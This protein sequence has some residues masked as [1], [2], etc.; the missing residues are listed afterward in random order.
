[1]R[2]LKAYKNNESFSVKGYWSL[3]F[4]KQMK[5]VAGILSYS[6]EK[7][8]LEL[9][10]SFDEFGEEKVS[11]NKVRI[12]GISINNTYITLFDCHRKYQKNSNIV[13][14]KYHV[15][16]FCIGDLFIESLEKSIFYNF[17]LQTSNMKNWFSFQLLDVDDDETIFNMTFDKNK[18]G[19]NL[20]AFNLESERLVIKETYTSVVRRNIGEEIKID[21]DNYLNVSSNDVLSIQDCNTIARKIISVF[22]LLQGQ[23]ENISF[24]E[25]YLIDES[26]KR[27]PIEK[28]RYYFTPLRKSQLT[29]VKNSNFRFF[30]NDIRGN[31]ESILSLYFE[32]NELLNEIIQMYIGDIE[33]N[34][35]I[36]TKFLN[37]ARAL[38]IYSRNFLKSVESSDDASIE[39]AREQLIKILE[40]EY[41]KNNKIYSYFYNKINYK[42]ET[43][44][45]SRISD[46]LRLLPENIKGNLIKRKNKSMNKSIKSFVSY[47]VQTRNYHTHGDVNQEKY[48]CL[49]TDNY[50]LFLM[51]KKMTLIIEY[52][53]L[54]E[55]GMDKES[56]SNRL[57]N[58]SQYGYLFP[59]ATDNYEFVDPGNA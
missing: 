47:I 20:K 42:S 48:S 37:N 21:I 58:S 59:P 19:N 32:K 52:L 11:N 49:I 35:F 1:M 33:K 13:F 40:D 29:P 7:I 43:N 34:P 25:M 45:N 57:L 28:V 6:E 56:V 51:N 14:V 8:E 54:T 38:E 30:Y 24:L 22:T 23:Y 3:S 55:L 12:E 26:N 9:F 31:M 41:S 10:D 2:N 5:E 53:L 39:E 36:E 46:I 44:L 50:D 17:N 15:G 27:L 16:S 18:I 4:G